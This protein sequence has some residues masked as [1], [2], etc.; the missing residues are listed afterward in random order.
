MDIGPAGVLAQRLTGLLETSFDPF[1]LRATS[2]D[3]G[4]SHAL[5]GV[6]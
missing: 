6:E 3:G 4:K 2:Q 1:S 5:Q